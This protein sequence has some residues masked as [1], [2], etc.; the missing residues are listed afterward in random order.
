MT[1]THAAEPRPPDAIGRVLEKLCHVFA[2][3]GG[4]VLIGITIMSALSILG[5]ALLSKPITGDFELVQLACAVCVAAFLPYAQQQRA[6][7]I[8]DFFTANA[9]PKIQAR[10]DAI[11]A[12]LV[13]VVTGLVC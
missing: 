10:L 3:A 12:L 1:E 11:G 4:V 6:N 9:S 7:I 13:G 5:R 8:V 2:A